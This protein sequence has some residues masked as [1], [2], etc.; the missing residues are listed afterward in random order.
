M[1]YASADKQSD[2]QKADKHAINYKGTKSGNLI[3]NILSAVYIFFL[4]VHAQGTKLGNHIQNILSVKFIFFYNIPKYDKG[5]EMNI[6]SILLSLKRYNRQDKDIQ[7][8]L[9]QR[10]KFGRSTF[11]T[12]VYSKTGSRVNKISVSVSYVRAICF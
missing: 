9:C 6:L 1:K 11:P 5:R 2:K 10:F 7:Y 4:I 12:A 8:Q 3:K